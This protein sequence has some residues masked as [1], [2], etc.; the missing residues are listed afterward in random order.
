[1]V[2]DGQALD[3]HSNL[4]TADA[5]PGEEKSETGRPKEH[6]DQQYGIQQPT[7]SL[8]RIQDIF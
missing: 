6:P 2:H 3:R 8:K 5:Y 1:V 4:R 7:T